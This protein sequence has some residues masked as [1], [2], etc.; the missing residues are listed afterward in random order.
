MKLY[1]LLASPDEPLDLDDYHEIRVRDTGWFG[2]DKID[3][4]AD[5]L[6]SEMEGTWKSG[7]TMRL[8]GFCQKP[9]HDVM[10]LFDVVITY[11][12]RPYFTYT[13]TIS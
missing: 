7:E 6:Y 8:V 1:C 5:I 12:L 13:N 4:C 11:E 3:Y 10:P 9:S 2:L